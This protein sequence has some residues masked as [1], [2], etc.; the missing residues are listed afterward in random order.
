MKKALLLGKKITNDIKEGK[1][2][3][4]QNFSARLILDKIV[5]PNFLKIIMKNKDGKLRGV[6]NYLFAHNMI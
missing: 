2:Y 5:K 3:P 1:T 4:L 6:Y